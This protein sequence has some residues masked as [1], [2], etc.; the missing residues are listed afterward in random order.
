MNTP[1]TIERRSSRLALFLGLLALLFALLVR[2]L[3]AQAHP[4]DVYLQA[5]YI[6]VAPAQVVVELDLSP[7]V[8]VAPQVLPLLDPD[9]DQQ[10][11]D[12]EGRAYADSV[13]RNVTLQVDGQAL[14]LAVTKIDM[15]QYLAIQAGYGTIRVFTTAALADGMTGTHTIAYVNTNAPTGAAYQVNTFVEQ[16]AAITLGK[17]NRDGIQQS[18]TV[19]Y[20]IGDVAA[21]APAASAA[22]DATDET[23]GVPAN[24]SGQVR[25]LLDSLYAPALSPW[26]LL[27]ALAVAALAGGLHALTPGHGKTLVAAYLVGS[28]GTVRHAAAL[29]GIVTFTHTASVILIGVLALFA[30]RFVVPGVLAPVLE[31][32]SG[33]LVVAMGAWLVRQRWGAFHQRRGRQGVRTPDHRHTHAGGPAHAYMH[34]HGDGRI[35]SHLPPAAGLTPR[36]LVAMGI[37]GGLVPCPEALGIMIVAIGLGR[38]PLGLGLIL[39]FSVG[40][41]AVL[42]AIGVL[43]VRARALIERYGG[44]GRRR[45]SAA[46]PLASAAIVTALGLG[47]TL[48]GLATYRGLPDSG[49]SLPGPRGIAL[50]ALLLVAGLALRVAK[51]RHRSRRARVPAAAAA[52]ASA[53]PMG[54]APLVHDDAGR[55]RRRDDAPLLDRAR[56][57][58]RPRG[59]RASRRVEEA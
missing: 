19:D 3:A 23:T 37:S 47:I 28:R 13:L 45:W 26:A 17:Q 31:I 7:G 48:R 36:G 50:V 30:S 39:S 58:C 15:P 10:I 18:M 55:D 46:L 21:S 56:V 29:G 5:T 49:R 38:I 53:A 9:A 34:D 6:T 54:A 33:A 44:F 27:L 8:L 20:A 12:A 52:A 11:T 14:P 16:G 4:L 51:T 40:L 25:R 59:S 2:P 43:L 35:H 1:R 41:A 24:A 42:I 22:S 57:R 32:L